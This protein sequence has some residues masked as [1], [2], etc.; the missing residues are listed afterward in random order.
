M[1]GRE[2]AERNVIDQ[3]RAREPSTEQAVMGLVFF[4]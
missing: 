4:C 1:Q 3:N 2:G